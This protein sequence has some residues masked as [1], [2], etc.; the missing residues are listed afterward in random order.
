MVKNFSMETLEY[1]KKWTQW[2][3]HTT[4]KTAENFKRFLFFIRK[5]LPWNW[6]KWREKSVPQECCNYF[7][8]PLDVYEANPGRNPWTSRH[9]CRN[10]CEKLQQAFLKR[11]ERDWKLPSVSMPSNEMFKSIILYI[12]MN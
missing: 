10:L 6:L 1:Y 2:R 4:S 7:S 12:F 11:K 9:C 3:F 8:H 5:V